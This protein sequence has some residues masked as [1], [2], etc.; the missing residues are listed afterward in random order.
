MPQNSSSLRKR[1]WRKLLALTLCGGLI[2]GC[3][4]D[5]RLHYFGG[6]RDLAYY[7][8]Q[9]LKIEYP[10]VD[11]P[12]PENVAFSHSPR[13]ISD[14]S[15][16]EDPWDM[17]LTEAI[18]LA[19][20]NNKVIRTAVNPGAP[21]S[22][23]VLN[24]PDGIVTVYDP[25]IRESGVL[26]GNRGVESALAAFD[27][28]WTTRMQWKANSNVLNNAFFGGLPA[29][30]TLD[31][32]G[33]QFST[34]LQKAYAYGAQM[35]LTHNWNY[36]RNNQPARFFHSA[37]EGGLS[38]NYRQPLWGGSGTEFTRT[39]GP[40]SDNI[41]GLSGVNQGV[42]IARIN[43]D[44]S[45]V[46]FESNVRNM[47][48]DVERQYWDLYLAYRTYDSEVTR[49]N[50]AL[51]TWKE[52]KTKFDVGGKGGSAGDESQAR[53]T[54]YE[55]RARTESALQTLYTAEIQLRRL[56]GLPVSDGRLIR[57]ADE[58]VTA[59]FIPE[60]HISLAEALTRREELRRQKWNIKSFELQYE[61]AKNLA[62]PRF[63]F[64]SSY[65]INGF[66]DELFNHDGPDPNSPDPSQA[67]RDSFQS[68][69]RSLTRANQDGWGAGF[70]F[71]FPF[72]LRNVTTQARNQELR[73]VRARDILAAQEL[74]V[75]HQ[76]ASAFQTLAFHY[77][78]AQTNFNRR[79][80]AERQLQA[81]ETEYRVGTKTLDLLL[82]AQTRLALAETAYFNSIVSY[83]KE[84]ANVHFLKGTLLENYN[85]H[86]SEGLWSPEAYNDALRRA[87]ARTYAK[88]MPP[89]AR[90]W[91]EPDPVTTGAEVGT[92]T[93]FL[94]SHQPSGVLMDREHP[95]MPFP[96]GVEVPPVP[97]AVP[98]PAALPP[99]TNIIPDLPPE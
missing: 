79:R 42:L 52:V 71:S 24:N 67:N 33:A 13:T 97:A 86:L 23:P 38:L 99:A 55:A 6:E 93:E 50:S 91:S 25:A 3:S 47:L 17:P 10:L 84:I 8:E 16:H 57:P 41:Q 85:V 64:V 45:L 49:R 39:A 27:T 88:D 73:L 43:T 59:E 35:S 63:D 82:Q 4:T 20:V 19:L 28:Q 60:W 98:L 1:R 5:K 74:E 56:C 48:Y 14:R 62:R 44:I 96:E 26:F 9:S 83:N 37:Y 70:E 30:S 58:P 78:N 40:L 51:R 31:E 21:T 2:A 54:Y 69:Y 32:D 95:V 65:N 29:G 94:D 18:H 68:A 12:T 15:A 7:E 46:D 89:N 80:S 75:S 11:E 81:I 36:T 72:G 61:A 53:E 22:N 90:V 92:R 66:G 34:A 76:L 77:D 87:W